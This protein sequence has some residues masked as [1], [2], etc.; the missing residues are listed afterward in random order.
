[1][2]KREI[3]ILLNHLKQFM[4]QFLKEQTAQLEPS[5]AHT[6]PNAAFG[7]RPLNSRGIS[8]NYTILRTDL[9]FKK[10]LYDLMRDAEEKYEDAIE[11]RKS[12]KKTEFKR[13][14]TKKEADR[15]LANFQ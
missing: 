1:M 11:S 7:H 9:E 12:I 13:V 5:D 4:T 15:A 10:Q 3:V 14:F 2:F 6:K 8:I